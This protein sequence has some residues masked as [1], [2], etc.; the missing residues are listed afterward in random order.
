MDSK[1]IKNQVQIYKKLIKYDKQDCQITVEL[2]YDDECNNGHNTFSITGNIFRL[3]GRK[4]NN[5][6]CAGCI[7]EEIAKYF[8][9]FRH[10][11][12]WH[13]CTSDGPMYYLENT[14][15][16]AS[17][18]TS[19]KYKVG[20]PNRWEKVLTFNNSHISHRF[21]KEFI[22]FLEDKKKIKYLILLKYN[23]IKIQ[24]TIISLDIRLKVLN[25][26][27]GSVLLIIKK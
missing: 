18:S 21:P 13:L 26:N 5:P 8:P 11:I 27:G 15:Y 2:R 4:R 25:V 3:N 22:N 1:L 12:K 20:E 9:K 7:H 6:I 19:S 14:L 16:Y 10:L 23:T 17:N 24:I